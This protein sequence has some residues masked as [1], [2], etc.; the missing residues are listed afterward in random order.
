MDSGLFVSNFTLPTPASRC[1]RRRA[2]T[3]RE[4]AK[5]RR[6]R[7]IPGKREPN[8][9]LTPSPSLPPSLHNRVPSGPAQSSSPKIQRNRRRRGGRWVNMG[10]PV[11]KLLQ[12]SPFSQI[13]NREGRVAVMARKCSLHHR[14]SFLPSLPLSLSPSMKVSFSSFPVAAVFRSSFSNLPAVFFYG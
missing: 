7:V 8:T 9:P 5:K 6:L 3:P 1:S 12:S 14:P 4:S 13:L 10:L 11:P 2:A